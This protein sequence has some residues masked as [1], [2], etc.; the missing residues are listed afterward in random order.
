M[1]LESMSMELICKDGVG[2]SSGLGSVKS[3]CVKVE[4]KKLIESAGCV[5]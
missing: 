2:M 3:L 5:I 1:S 4:F